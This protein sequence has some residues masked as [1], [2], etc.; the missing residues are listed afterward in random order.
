M[1]N[2]VGATIVLA[3]DESDL[4]AVYA[5]CLRRSG[6]TVWEAADG[7]EAAAM[8]HAHNPD[9]LLLDLWMPI[10][11]GLEVLEQIRGDRGAVGLKVVMLTHQRDADTRLEG[12]ALGASAYWTKDIS[13]LELSSKIESLLDSPPT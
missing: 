10:L 7:A 9:L 4:R 12:F 11:N 2:D 1:R 13:L 8:V 3:E 5:E 6:H